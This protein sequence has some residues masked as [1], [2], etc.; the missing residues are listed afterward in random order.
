MTGPIVFEAPQPATVSR[1][2]RLVLA[3]LAAL[4]LLGA[5]AVMEIGA[6]TALTVFSSAHNHGG[7]N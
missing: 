3:L 1:R 5:I 4:V 2:A 7:G 6:V